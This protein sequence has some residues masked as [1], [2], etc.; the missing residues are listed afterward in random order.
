MRQALLESKRAREEAEKSVAPK[1]DGGKAP[2]N[3]VTPDFITAVAEVLAFGAAKY[4]AWSW[5]EGKAWSRD[6]AAAL[7]HMMAWANGEDLD[8]ESGLPHLAHAACDLMFLITS[9]RRGLGTDD[10][11]KFASIEAEKK[12]LK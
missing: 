7:R 9:Q 5:A 8:T 12:R 3:L 10:R 2:L 4:E 1:F 6:H 11:H